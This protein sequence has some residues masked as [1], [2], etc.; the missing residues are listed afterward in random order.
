[1]FLHFFHLLFATLVPLSVHKGRRAFNASSPQAAIPRSLFRRLASLHLPT[2]VLAITLSDLQPTGRKHIPKPLGPSSENCA[3]RELSDSYHIT[4]T[5]KTASTSLNCWD[6]R[7]YPF[8]PSKTA[9]HIN[10]T[11]FPVFFANSGRFR[12]FGFAGA[13][14]SLPRKRK[15]L[16]FT[17]AM[18]RIYALS[19]SLLC[20]SASFSAS[21]WPEFRGPTG[22]GII[23]GGDKLPL[24]WSETEGVTWKTPIH[25][26]AWSSPV[27]DGTR[28][29][30]TTATTN[31][32]EL[33]AVSL[34]F[35][36]GRIL[37]DLKLFTVAKPQYAH[38][39]NTYASPTPVLEGS[40]VYVTFGAPGTACLD[41]GTGKTMWERR[42]L[43]CNHFRGAGSSPVIFKNLL[44]MN[45][46]GSDFQ[47]VIA[48][49]KTTGETVWKTN[50]SL[51]F[52]DL[53]PEG[54]PQ[55]DGDWRKAFSTPL[56]YD[57]G[58][59]PILISHGSKAVYGYE[60]LTG[61]ELWHVEEQKT[62]SGSG[63]PS[64]GHGMI[65][66]SMGH[67]KSELWAIK[68]GGK[69]DV[70]DS[71]VA[72]KVK[73][74]VPTRSSPILV[75]DLIFMAD[76]GGIASCLD[77]KT[78]GQKW[79]ERIG[80]NYSAAP[81]A[82]RDR[83]YFF[84]E[85]GKTTALAAAPEFK[86]LATSQL[87]DGFMAVPAVIDNSLILRSRTHLYRIQ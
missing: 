43:E 36:S 55:A 70:T 51:D 11:R 13:D 22:Q 24:K 10:A 57:F 73:R 62:H 83:I 85:D 39:F 48:L 21:V 44:I 60:P 19:L 46:D 20:S 9:Y 23:V 58:S 1:M 50:R 26:R 30:L 49:D 67:S 69:G 35:K 81:I 47:Y 53:T 59:G 86:I 29:W 16:N 18:I 15:S 64:A 40:R 14:S 3:H 74:N 12:R 28:I 61:K 76:D 32:T 56:I 33:F 45:F 72:W 82:T 66:V 54:K 65:F 80:G 8:A 7:D 78:G 25:G 77:A 79:N 27:S 17:P 2:Q 31:G 63:R 68:P 4:I 6:L 52:K 5:A 71:H 41:A 87:G 38:P 84:A 34:D 37:H 75:G 42:D